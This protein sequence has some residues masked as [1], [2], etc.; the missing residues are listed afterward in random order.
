MKSVLLKLVAGT[1]LKLGVAYA[2]RIVANTV[3][4]LR[5]VLDA[6]S[7]SDDARKSIASVVAVLIA[8]R[9]FLERLAELIG[10]PALGLQD[11]GSRSDLHDAGDKL[12][13]ITDSL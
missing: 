4:A 2:L 12:R 6:G 7:L 9:D 3:A 1:T 5:G 11:A 10:A 8:V 13:R